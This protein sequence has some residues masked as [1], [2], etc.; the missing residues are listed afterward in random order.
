MTV[1]LLTR[2]YLNT[3]V[4]NP[5]NVLLL[6]TVPAVFVLAASG[7]FA[8]FADVIGNVTNRPALE[9]NTAGWAAGFLVAVA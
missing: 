7:S 3:Y 1:G 5:V 2:R 6:V 9:A 8:K 4:R